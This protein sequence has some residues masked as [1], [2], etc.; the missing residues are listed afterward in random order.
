MDPA[1]E[2][3]VADMEVLRDAISRTRSPYLRK[4]YEKALRRMERD[5]KEYDRFKAELA[6]R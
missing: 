4:D 6:R 1:R 5:L 2:K 3:F